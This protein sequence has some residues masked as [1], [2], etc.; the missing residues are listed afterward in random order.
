M[1]QCFIMLG[2]LKKSR[3]IQNYV[4]GMTYLCFHDMKRE[5]L[6]TLTVTDVTI[7]VAPGSSLHVWIYGLQKEFYCPMSRPSCYGAYTSP[8]YLFLR[9]RRNSTVKT[10]RLERKRKPVE[11]KIWTKFGLSNIQKVLKIFCAVLNTS[12]CRGTFGVSCKT[13]L[14]DQHTGETTL[15][16]FKSRKE[17]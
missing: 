9:T 10:A 7:L 1:C 13:F 15:A 14:A 17:D 8:V 12:L 2:S 6:S 5:I 4:S 11:S 3:I 16:H